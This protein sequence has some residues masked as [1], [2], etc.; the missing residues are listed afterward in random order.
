MMRPLFVSGLVLLTSC[1]DAHDGGSGGGSATTATGSSGTTSA[2]TT[3]TMGAGGNVGASVTLPGGVSLTI[4]GTWL[5]A[6][7]AAPTEGT[8]NARGSIVDTMGQPLPPGTLTIGNGLDNL[9]LTYVDGEVPPYEALM[10]ELEYTGILTFQLEAEGDQ[11]FGSVPLDFPW[12]SDFAVS[13]PAVAANDVELT[14]TATPGATCSVHAISLS[15]GGSYLAQDFP[16]EGQHTIVAGELAPSTATRFELTCA[17][18]I[19]VENVVFVSVAQYR[20]SVVSV[21]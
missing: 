16:D 12:I 13:Q 17:K 5:A 1:S 3:S 10:A 2:G 18:L 4:H 11:G 8:L 19:G 7:D 6:S 14:W 21:E 9:P 20:E 15:S